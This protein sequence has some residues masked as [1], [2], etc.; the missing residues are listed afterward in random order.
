MMNTAPEFEA[1]FNLPIAVRLQLVED[2]W[3]SI[4]RDSQP[5]VPEE[6]RRELTRRHEAFET[7]TGSAITW[8]EARQR[9]RGS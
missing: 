2:L 5:D 9:L 4:A 7:D 1:L 8:E 6:V 3:D